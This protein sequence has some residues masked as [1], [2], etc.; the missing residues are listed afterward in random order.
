M[1]KTVAYKPQR[2][3]KLIVTVVVPGLTPE[4]NERD[5]STET[6][7]ALGRTKTTA[8]YASILRRAAHRFRC[9][10]A[11]RFRLQESKYALLSTVF[12][13]GTKSGN[14]ELDQEL[15]LLLQAF[16]EPFLPGQVWGE[17]LTQVF[18]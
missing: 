5:G 15:P 10:A 16:F 2:I 17:R 7:A 12:L 4:P 14:P 8:V 9:A 13:V 18:P 3:S 1:P 11:I 6:N